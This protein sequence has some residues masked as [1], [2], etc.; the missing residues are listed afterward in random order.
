MAVPKRRVS[1]ARRG[2]RRSHL[3]R[4]PVGYQYCS[5]CNDPVMPHRVCENCGWFQGRTVV[6]KAESDES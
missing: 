5:N 4:K 3:H 6:V 1:K 2:K